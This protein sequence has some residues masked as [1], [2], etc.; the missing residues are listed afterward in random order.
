MIGINILNRVEIQDY[1][2]CENLTK[3][4][5]EHAVLIN[6]QGNQWCITWI[7]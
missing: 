7:Q 2:Y 6:V 1:T 3:Y 5:V 4:C